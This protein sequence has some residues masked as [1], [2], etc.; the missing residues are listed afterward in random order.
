M[1]LTACKHIISNLPVVWP[2]VDGGKVN[3]GRIVICDEVLPLFSR[4]CAFCTIPVNKMRDTP[5]P[6]GMG[7]VTFTLKSKKALSEPALLLLSP[8]TYRYVSKIS[9][10]YPDLLGL[11]SGPPCVMN[12]TLL[13]RE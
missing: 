2:A 7:H 10:P 3:V 1:T 5:S 11:H 13:P 4:P 9:G 6:R 12:K 8:V